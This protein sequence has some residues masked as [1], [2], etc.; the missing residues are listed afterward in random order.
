MICIKDSGDIEGKPLKS[1]VGGSSDHR[2]HNTTNLPPRLYS[3]IVQ[4]SE[5]N[6]Q[7]GSM[8]QVVVRNSCKIIAGDKDC[9]DVEGSPLTLVPFLQAPSGMIQHNMC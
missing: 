9:I 8:L 5:E 7:F 3:T 6:D 4:R 1:G 2:S